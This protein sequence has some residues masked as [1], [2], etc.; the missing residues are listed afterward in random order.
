VAYELFAGT[1]PFNDKERA[2]MF[3]MHMSVVPPP[4]SAIDAK[5]PAAVDRIVMRCLEKD[6]K[7]RFASCEA[8][9]RDVVLLA[10]EP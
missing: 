10:E 2:R 9:R 6:P 5:L 3:Q 1:R 4:P 8:L 7:S